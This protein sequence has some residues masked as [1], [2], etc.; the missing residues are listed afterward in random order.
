LN[1]DET[2]KK[3][4][5]CDDNIVLYSGFFVVGNHSAKE[6][7]HMDYAD[8]ANAYTLITPLFELNYDHGNLLYKNS[9]EKTQTYTYKSGE[10]II[11]G[12]NFLHTTE[13]YPKNNQTRV[14]LSLT[15]GT[16]KL[17]YWGQLK[18]TIEGQ[19]EYFIL[20]CGH[21]FG[22]CECLEKL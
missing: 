19:S 22:T 7:W 9:G 15:F 8:G 10:A 20:P 21:Q 16:D 6:F 2:V 3:L 13:P 12:E 17:H 14:L 1:I 5:D 11:L 18:Q 4:V